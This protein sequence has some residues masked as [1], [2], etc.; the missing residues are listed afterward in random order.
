MTVE[1]E[2]FRFV[3]D[4]PHWKRKK[5]NVD[6][7]VYKKDQSRVGKV[8]FATKRAARAWEVE[9]EREVRSS[10]TQQ[11][12]ITFSV[13]SNQY[14]DQVEVTSTG[15][16]TYQ[17]KKRLILDVIQFYGRDP[18]LPLEPLDI[19]QFLIDKAR[20]GGPATANRARRELGTL[21]NWMIGKG[22]IETNPITTIKKFPAEKFKKYV[23]PR[24]DIIKVISAAGAEEKDIIRVAIHSMARAGELRRLKKEH[25]DFRNNT[26]T[27]YTRKTE[28]GT[29]EG[30]KI[31]MNNNLREILLRRSQLID[32]DYIFPSPSGV[33]LS[34]SSLDK[35]LPQIFDR[36]NTRKEK[37]KEI[38]NRKTKHGI[39]KQ[40]VWKT[41]LVQVPDD[42]YI[43]PF[44]LHAF[45]HYVTAHLYLHEG[46]TIGQLQKLL[47]HKKPTTTET[48]LKSIVD[49]DTPVGL[50]PMEDFEAAM[51]EMEDSNV[52]AFKG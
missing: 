39:V 20:S 6:L 11:T 34:K 22:I 37:Y 25:C 21:F 45:R 46:Y 16:N 13:Y 51:P 7:F 26:I 40:G 17:Y 5:P 36:L 3:L 32:S 8:K 31:P 47:R 52:R 23:P 38:V 27:L 19:E 15:E 9:H 4:R 44:G 49:M 2:E 35:M 33:E 48:Y 50:A 14:L 43:T 24:E 10:L 42:E 29:L 18:A 1:G 12:A 28:D 30:G 41:R